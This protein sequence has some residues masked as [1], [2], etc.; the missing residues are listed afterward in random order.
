VGEE[1]GVG[2]CEGCGEVS[3]R[4]E[5]RVGNCVLCR[6]HLVFDERDLRMGE[7]GVMRLGG[8]KIRW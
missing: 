3:V 8:L 4:R 6:R 1:R 2:G 7:C 5:Q